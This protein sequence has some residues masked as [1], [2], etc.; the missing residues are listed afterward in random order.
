[1]RKQTLLTG[2]VLALLFGVCV[3]AN[4]QEFADNPAYH[5]ARG[6]LPL[7]D[8]RPYNL[9][10]LQF[11]PESGEILSRGKT[12]Y[13]LQFDVANNLLA[14]AVRN[15]VRVYEDNEYQRLLATWRQGIGR[16]TELAVSVPLLWRNAGVLDGLL[17]AYHRLAGIRGNADDPIRRTNRPQNQ[18][19]LVLQDAAGNLLVNQGNGFGLGET[20]LTLKHRLIRANL[21]SALA[22]R[23]A[24]KV[25]TGNPSLLLGSGSFDAGI[26]LDAK[27]S[28]GR[29][30]IFY[31]NA[32]E[33]LLGHSPVRGSRRNLFQGFIGIEYRPNN[34]DSFL[35]QIDG[36]SLAVRTGNG[37]A[38]KIQSTLTFGYKRVLDRNLV[39]WLALAENGDIN[40]YR[41]PAFGGI[42]PD[43]TFSVGLEWHP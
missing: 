9:L 13:A 10:F 7:R 39:G 34:R 28:V 31:A 5:A 23:L 15:G 40:N 17:N 12:R 25:P 1:M 42:A 14:P 26:S 37:V 21:R 41:A 22:L 29:D 30:V 36:S 2:L 43:V 33:V 16:D 18:S 6:P 19:H 11:A 4:A 20:S 35:L 27:Y 24:M 8:L 32:G 3:P 38:D